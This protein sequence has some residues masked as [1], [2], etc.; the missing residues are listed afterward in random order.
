LQTERTLLDPDLLSRIEGLQLRARR[1]VEGYYA[2]VHRS[3]FHGYSVEFAE[4]REYSPGDD[5]RYVDWK[6]F[7]KTD[8]VYV[9]RYEEETN[10]ACY[11]LLDQSES[12]RYQGPNSSMSKFEYARLLS[13]AL[14]YLVLGQ[15]DSVGL[16]TFDEQV[17]T[18]VRANSQPSH[19]RPILETL[20]AAAPAGKTSAAPVFH[21]LAERFKKRSVMIL[22]SD[23]LDDV[24]ALLAGLKH[25]QHRRHEV[26]VMHL[27][28]AAELE[29]PFD[30]TTLFRGLEE[31][32]DILVDPLALRPAYL[33]ELHSYL[34]QVETGVRS[35]QADYI[36]I[37]TDQRLDASL[38]RY[39]RSRNARVSNQ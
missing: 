18:E 38:S 5:L 15:Q 19:L 26:I 2:G 4:H 20:V 16:V 10:L 36:R 14:A 34:R 32:P 11:L 12:M 6:V 37:T 7:G 25:F 8:K 9:K 29:F 28:D 3:P 24:P 17:Q 39:L 31:T 35:Q 27:L 1:I 13:A 30:R 33:F 21:E 23:L 22:L